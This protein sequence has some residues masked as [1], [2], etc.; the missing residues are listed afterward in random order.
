MTMMRCTKI[1]KDRHNAEIRKL[2]IR[3]QQ[4]LHVALQTPAQHTAQPVV[5]GEAGAGKARRRPAGETSPKPRDGGTVRR[6]GCGRAEQA[7]CVSRASAETTRARV[8]VG[9]AR[10]A[11]HTSSSVLRKYSS[12]SSCTGHQRLS[13]PSCFN[14]Y[15]AMVER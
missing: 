11:A 10:R 9:L 6:G 13:L 4:G 5:G 15:D 8:G 3:L 12:T 1:A 2:E 7:P 14:M